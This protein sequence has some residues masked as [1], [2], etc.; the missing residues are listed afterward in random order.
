MKYKILLRGVKSTYKAESEG[1]RV[2]YTAEWFMLVR[3]T[4]D[5]GGQVVFLAPRESVV[6][7]YAVE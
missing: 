7:A 5:S 3:E 2:Q 1:D 4:D 6:Y